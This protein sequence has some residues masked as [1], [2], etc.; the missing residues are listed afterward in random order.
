VF[1]VQRMRLSFV[2]DPF[3]SLKMGTDSISET[4]CFLV[5]L[6]ADDEEF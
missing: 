1:R 6:N 4:L 2:R 3:L 5:I